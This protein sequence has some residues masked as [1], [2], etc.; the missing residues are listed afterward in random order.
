MRKQAEGLWGCHQSHGEGLTQRDT[1]SAGV[2]L[3]QDLKEHFVLKFFITRYI[4]LNPEGFFVWW[5]FIYS[6]LICE[7]CNKHPLTKELVL[8][9]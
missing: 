7:R 4:F 6:I 5:V 1:G 2:D 9:V 8:N 3:W